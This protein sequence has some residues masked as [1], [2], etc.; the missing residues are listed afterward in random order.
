MESSALPSGSDADEGLAIPEGSQDAAS[1]FVRA[2]LD[3]DPK[4]R[5][6][7]L[8]ATASPE[9]ADELG[10]TDPANIPKATVVGPPALA[11]ASTYSAQFTQAL[12]GG[13]RIEVY[14]VA[15][16][17]APYGWLATSVDRA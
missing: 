9:L 2:W 3:P 7:A 14:L 10:Q 11:D 1:R 12:S 4:T 16:P 17:A 6:P 5:K 13:L 8:R 15:D